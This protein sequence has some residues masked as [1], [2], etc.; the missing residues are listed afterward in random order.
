MQDVGQK[1]YVEQGLC[2]Y[3]DNTAFSLMCTKCPRISALH[4]N[5]LLLCWYST[6]TARLNEP[7]QMWSLISECKLKQNISEAVVE[8]M[9]QMHDCLFFFSPSVNS[10][11][12]Q[13]LQSHYKRIVYLMV[14]EC[15]PN[16]EIMTWKHKAEG[17][18][19]LCAASKT[20][21]LTKC[22]FYLTNSLNQTQVK[23]PA[24]FLP[25]EPDW[26]GLWPQIERQLSTHFQRGKSQNNNFILMDNVSIFRSSSGFFFP[27]RM[28]FFNILASRFNKGLLCDWESYVLCWWVFK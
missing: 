25:E 19:V 20:F 24:P 11:I 28:Y 10:N 22:F 6:S 9:A 14:A 1:V 4:S 16:K 26:R 15:M 13:T 23:I 12:I 5:S 8:D 3:V 27:P 7:W 17:G 2:G 18:H 21:Y